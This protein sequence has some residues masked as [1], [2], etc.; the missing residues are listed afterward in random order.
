MG[1]DGGY[2]YLHCTDKAE[3]NR[4]FG[5]FLWRYANTS[6]RA[7]KGSRPG[8]SDPTDPGPDYVEGGYGTDCNSSFEDVVNMI[9]YVLDDRE[10]WAAMPT[11]PRDLT[12]RDL[13]E[14]LVTDPE[15]DVDQGLFGIRVSHYEWTRWWAIHEFRPL[16]E[17]L[18]GSTRGYSFA[19]IDEHVLDM[20]LREWCLALRKAGCD[21]AY[22]E[23]TWT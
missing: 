11:D 22:T 4:L 5:C 21:H 3:F 14:D 20:T 9:A 2:C 6:C 7:I 18:A 13:V 10:R 12:F 16:A 23:E 15:F 8:D 19:R 1:A 17:H